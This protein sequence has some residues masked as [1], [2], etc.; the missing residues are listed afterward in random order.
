MNGDTT[1]KIDE[2]IQN[3]YDFRFGDYISKGFSLLQKNIGGFII[4]A[5]VTLVLIMVINFIPIIGA[6]VSNFI[7][8][9]ILTVGAYIVAYKLDKGEQ[10][11]FGDFFKGF[12]YIGP[13]ALTAL[14]TFAIMMLSLIPFFLAVS[15]SGLIAWYMDVLQNPMSMSGVSIPSIPGWSFLLLLPAVYFA[16]AYNWAYMFVVFYKMSFW[17][18][19]ES[20]RKVIS[21]NWMIIFLFLF[22]SGL[23]AAAGIIVLCV[24]ILVTFPAYLCMNYSAFADVTQLGT[25]SKES[26]NIEN[27]L[28]D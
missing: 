12:E 27:H 10:T 11:E 9:P 26:D 2:I 25:E 17:D 7:L 15:S 18:A 8:T 3:G 22:V 24:G 4:Y 14:A 20:S 6:L 21:K 23:I 5:V 19:M 1:D 13:L 16:V 28:V